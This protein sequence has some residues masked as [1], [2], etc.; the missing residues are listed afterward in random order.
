MRKY[1][2][3]FCDEYKY[4]KEVKDLLSRIVETIVETLNPFSIILIG[5]LARGEVTYHIHRDKIDFLSDIEMRIVLDTVKERNHEELK[6]NLSKIEAMGSSN[7]LFHIDFAINRVCEIKRLSPIVRT[8]ETKEHGKILYGENVLKDIPRVTTESLDLGKTRELILTRLFNLFLFIPKRI[9][10]NKATDYERLI[11]NYVLCRNILDIPTILLPLSG[12]LLPNYRD[13]VNYIANN[14]PRQWKN[15][16]GED[17]PELLIYALRGKYELRF[18]RPVDEI[19]EKTLRGYGGLLCWVLSEKRMLELDELCKLIQ[20]KGLSLLENR[21]LKWKVYETWVTIRYF[22]KKNLLRV[23]RG[24]IMKKREAF[25]CYLLYMHYTLLNY[26]NGDKKNA[27]SFFAKAK[28]YQK[29]FLFKDKLN[30]RKNTSLG[31]SW[32]NMRKQFIAQSSIILAFP[33]KQKD[34]FQKAVEWEENE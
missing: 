8:F 15:L 3:L 20:A 26:I 27:Q 18:D 29:S 4:P 21:W 13:R 23:V 31:D 2:L 30:K 14:Y 12:I 1:N 25:I 33:A 32:L 16:F 24:L 7:F 28:E 19:Y 10:I 17:F 34:Y 5:S 22:S 6:R 11:F 9:V